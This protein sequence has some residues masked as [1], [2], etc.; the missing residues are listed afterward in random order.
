M[1]ELIIILI[2]IFIN[3]LIEIL[4]NI[5]ISLASRDIDIEFLLRLI[6]LLDNEVKTALI[7]I[8]CQY[9]IWLEWLMN[10]LMWLYLQ[11]RYWVIVI[12]I[13]II[14]WWDISI[15]YIE[16]FWKK[17]IILIEYFWK[18]SKIEIQLWWNEINL[19]ISKFDRE[20]YLKKKEDEL[21]EIKQ[22][23]QEIKQELGFIVEIT[24]YYLNKWWIIYND[25]KDLKELWKQIKKDIWDIWDISDLSDLFNNGRWKKQFQPILIINIGYDNELT[26]L[27]LTA[28]QIDPNWER[29]E[30]LI[31]LQV[32]LF[33]LICAEIIW[34]S[35]RKREKIEK[36]IKKEEK[37]KRQKEASQELWRQL[38]K[39]KKK[40]KDLW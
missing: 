11:I 16:Y 9:G 24:K 29:L 23:L 40:K 17:S 38:E 31:A 30:K 7:K 2:Q 13:K 5:A 26:Y 28:D 6:L 37:I 33:Y 36:E 20:A 14:L 12:Y 1:Q 34:K 27:W 32:L 22:W 8:G 4:A 21:Q 39:R 15:I 18:K 3:S 10:N 19:E 35:K 25:T